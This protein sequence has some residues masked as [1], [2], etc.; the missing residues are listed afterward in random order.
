ML[1]KFDVVIAC[2]LDRS[3]G[4]G[5][6]VPF[7]IPDEFTHYC[8]LISYEGLKNTIISGRSSYDPDIFE[9]RPIKHA[10]YFVLSTSLDQVQGATVFRSLRSTLR[11]AENHI[12]VVGGN[13]VLNSILRSPEVELLDKIYFTRIDGC[14]EADTYLEGYTDNIYDDGFFGPHFTETYRSTK[15]L[16]GEL[17]YE[18]TVYSNVASLETPN[19]LDLY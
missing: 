12:F 5:T 14:F 16:C 19:K 3:F 18:Y 1:N 4:R 11:Q 6:R 7:N 13:V 9:V 2:G 10:N 8:R 15:Q 17:S